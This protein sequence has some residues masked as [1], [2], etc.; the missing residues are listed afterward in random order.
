VRTAAPETPFGRL[1][2][3]PISLSEL[4]DGSAAVALLQQVQLL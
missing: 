1:Q 2:P 4:G 3:D